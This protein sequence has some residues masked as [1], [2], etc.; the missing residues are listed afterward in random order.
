VVG[1]SAPIRFTPNM[2]SP[3]LR[4]AQRSLKNLLPRLNLK[5]I[6]PGDFSEAAAAL[7]G[8]EGLGLSVFYHR[9]CA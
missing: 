7:L 2:L 4:W 3:Y 5:G 9:A 1:D 8:P 6:S